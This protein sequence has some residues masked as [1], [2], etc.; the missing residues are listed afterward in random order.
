MFPKASFTFHIDWR[1]VNVRSRGF[2][3]LLVHNYQHNCN[4]N[5]SVILTGRS[6]PC[7]QSWVG[8]IHHVAQCSAL[9]R[10]HCMSTYSQLVS[11]LLESC[12]ISNTD[13]IALK[14]YI[15][16]VVFPLKLG[17]WNKYYAY[18]RE[19]CIETSEHRINIP[20]EGYN[21]HS[22]EAHSTADLY[23]NEAT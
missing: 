23:Y 11:F 7:I 1:F 18:I 5:H 6:D 12:I 4:K 19:Y 22:F 3:C 13:Q 17:K 20:H 16:K 9:V 15:P 10:S 2:Y 21:P 8:F 14:L